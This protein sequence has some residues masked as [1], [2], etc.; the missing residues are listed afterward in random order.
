MRRSRG[1]SLLAAIDLSAGGLE[2]LDE[3]LRA[4]PDAAVAVWA[5]GP[6]EATRMAERLVEHDGPALLHPPPAL[7]CLGSGV[8]L[9][10]GWV[11]LSGIPAL[12]RL[13]ASSEARVEVVRL[14]V[15]GLPEGVGTGL[16]P[17]LY[18][19]ATL[20]HRFGRHVRMERA[21]LEDEQHLALALEVD[22]APW[23]VEVAAGRGP[24]LN[25][26]VRTA[27][28]DY[29]WRVDAVSESLERPGA[30]PRAMPVVPWAERCIRQLASPARGADLA[31]ARVARGFLDAVETALERRLPPTPFVHEPQTPSAL[32]T[33]SELSGAE[34]GPRVTGSFRVPS[35]HELEAQRPSALARLGLMGELPDAAPLAPTPPPSSELPL[36][37]LA[38][39]LELRPAV[40]LTVEPE[41]E[42]RI[43]ALLPGTVE[44]RERRVDVRPGDQWHDDRT[45]GRPMVELF[46]SR[47]AQAARRLAELQANDPTEAAPAMGALL[48]YPACCVQAFVAQ[49]D[50]ADN[51]YN[52]YA[53]AARTAWGPGLWPSS[54]DD[55]SLKLLPHFPCTYRC[56]RSREQARTLLSA[57]AMEDAPLQARLFAYLHGPVLYF[58]HDH[59]VRFHG[60]FSEGGIAYHRVSIP[61]VG[62][63]PFAQLAG[64]L[65]T[66]DRLVLTEGALSVHAGERRV[67]TL[68]RTDP[69]LGLVL[70]FGV[71]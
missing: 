10:H 16:G 59:Q 9:T 26:V 23:R 27:H 50:R 57:L 14:Q 1:L 36:E 67:F 6:L 35:A 49:L 47:D 2:G 29:R 21:V 3:A 54:L 58:D 4:R 28:G 45:S 68:E 52:R 38:Y 24:A 13:F 11:S 48:G 51:S 62:T 56:E 17:A 15:R 22:G 5:S 39:A 43:R 46:A 69:G 20:V 12:E 65:A 8:Q 37:A 32:A 34:R 53:I 18:H 25:L 41:H 66:G 19:A 33:G 7:A 55:T 63:P 71:P 44:R 42:T 64:A 30:E 40:F 31:D 60:T 61:W 70:P